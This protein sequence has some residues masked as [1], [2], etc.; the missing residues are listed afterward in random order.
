M[1]TAFGAIW[2]YIKRTDKLLW[3]YAFLLSGIGIVMIFS[4][5]ASGFVSGF[6]ILYVQTGATVL[7]V[8]VA[9]V[10]SKIDYHMIA[11]MWKIFVPISLL[12]VLLTFTP[13]GIM[14]EGSDD[15]AWL[16]LG[17]IDF[18]PSEVLKL[19]FVFT[20][21][22]HISQL[23][24]DINRIRNLLL[25]CAHAA[26]PILLI[27]AQGDLGSA[28]VFVMVFIFMMF[29]GGLE[30]KYIA[31]GLG[32][33]VLGILFVY[34]FIL[35]QAHKGR[36][37]L[38]LNPELDPMGLGYQQ[39]QGKIAL[40]SGGLLGKG[41]LSHNL[42]DTVPEIYN[43]FIYAHIGQTMGFVGCVGVAFVILLFCIKILVVGK[44]VTD[45]LGMLVCVGVFT[46]MII[47]SVINIGMVLCVMPVIGVTLPLVSYGG[48]SV[49]M[50]YVSI[51][52]VLSVHIN[53]VKKP[54]FDY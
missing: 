50:T 28:I 26:L 24:D 43:D 10:V 49:V 22:M 32:V 18:Q 3:L 20:L 16:S 19:A 42:M 27:V 34:Y 5:C 6:K 13:L 8:I 23:G 48:T 38:A 29:A 35:S 11:N 46:I 36:L 45:N 21:A 53:G 14:R 33:V 25:L 2:D 44:S 41:I 51:G 15:R 17:F 47:Q 37:A 1:K 12:L 4:I 31:I 7:G 9:I 52:I 39:V 40:G 30:W 54:A